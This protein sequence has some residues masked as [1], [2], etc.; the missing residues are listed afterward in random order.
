MPLT[1][2]TNGED[3][4]SLRKDRVH[5]LVA[6]KINSKRRDILPAHDYKQWLRRR[7]E[8]VFGRIV[9]LFPKRIYATTLSGFLLKISLFLFTYQGDKAFA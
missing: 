4:L 9:K 7:I 5:P 6:R 3:H 2:I 1:L 8:T